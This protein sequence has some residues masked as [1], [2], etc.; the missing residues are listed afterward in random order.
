[1]EK[2]CGFTGLIE[3]RRQGT[4][5]RVTKRQNL[6]YSSL[7]EKLALILIFT[8]S[9]YFKEGVMPEIP[10]KCS[11][12]DQQVCQSKKQRGRFLFMA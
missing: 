4:M 10:R 6:F 8:Q 11:L 1:M 7:M 12:S 9:G 2:Y 5:A 3:E